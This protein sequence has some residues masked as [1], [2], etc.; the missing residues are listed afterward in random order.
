M[1]EYCDNARLLG[2]SKSL[3]EGVCAVIDGDKLRISGWFDG[4][5]GIQPLCIPVSYCPKCGRDLRG[6]AE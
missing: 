5:A 4:I 2:K 1:C 3:I 6:G